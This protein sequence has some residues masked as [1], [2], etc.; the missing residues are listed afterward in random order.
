MWKGWH[1]GK[2]GLPFGVF[3]EGTAGEVHIASFVFFLWGCG[4]VSK[5]LKVPKL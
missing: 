2:E 3:A 4:M 1:V 5:S